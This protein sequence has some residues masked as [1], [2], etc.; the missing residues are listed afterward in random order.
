MWQN[1]TSI[2][3]QFLGGLAGEGSGI[4][5]VV[6]RVR[7]P[8]QECLHATAAAKQKKQKQKTPKTWCLP[9]LARQQ[10][11][12]S[13]RSPASAVPPGWA[14]SFV[15]CPSSHWL[16]YKAWAWHSQ[17]LRHFYFPGK[18]E[19]WCH[20][21]WLVLKAIHTA[22]RRACQRRPWAPGHCPAAAP[23][24]CSYPASAVR[25][26]SH[27]QRVATRAGPS[28]QQVVLPKET[29]GSR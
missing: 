22:V 19:A 24:G 2:P 25:T 8:A 27:R 7:T 1:L 12:P 29:Q 18:S 13:C 10:P 21:L 26:E 5:T 14:H 20:M 28:V 4:A 11:L 3:G 23:G 9:A 6:A 16:S 17:T 15:F